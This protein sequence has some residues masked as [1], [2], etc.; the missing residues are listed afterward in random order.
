MPTN[1]IS[2]KWAWWEYFVLGFVIFFYTALYVV[3]KQD[4][5]YGDAISTVSRAAWHITQSSFKS[6]SYP[7]GLDPGHPITFPLIYASIWKIFGTGLRQSHAINFIFSIL[8]SVLVWKWVHRE[9]GKIPAWIAVFLLLCVPQFVANTAQMNTHLPLTFFA[10]GLGYSLRFE[11]KIG[12]IA[13]STALLITH[14]QGLYFLAPLWIWWLFQNQTISFQQKVKYALNM[15][16]IP[17]LFFCFWLFYHHSITGWWLSSP[18]YAGHRGTPGIKRIFINLILSD[19]RIVD[20]GQIGLFIIPIYLFFRKN[21]GFT[22]N[23]PFVLFLVIYFFNAI[24]LSI[25]TQTGPAHRYLLACL[26]FL[27]IANAQL[28]DKVSLSSRILVVILLISGHFWFYPG[29]VMG[30]ATLANRDIDYLLEELE[31]E[32]PKTEMYSYAPL[33]NSSLF[34]RLSEGL[35]DYKPLYDL[36]MDSAEYIIRSNLSG[37]FKA[38]ELAELQQ[39]W[40]VRTYEKGYVYLEVYANPAM[41]SISNPN[42]REIGWL[43]KN[44]LQLKRFIKGENAH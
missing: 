30:D 29:K 31:K 25:T 12:Q 37:D 34:T 24:A 3:V 21:F 40:S 5:F 13:F 35:V 32:F 36:S 1:R 7:P 26:P 44:M 18:D 22:W 15:L 17:I 16:A 8:T 11:L 10:L 4:S 14:L 43:E 2:S 41:T 19:W 39:N 9:S 38:D 6:I 23:H 28:L 33:S 42:R 27:V 20:Y